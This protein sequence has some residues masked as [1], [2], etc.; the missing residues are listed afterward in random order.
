MDLG[1][2]EEDDRQD[3]PQRRAPMD[4]TTLKTPTRQEAMIPLTGRQ[5]LDSLDDGREVW[6]YG[7]RVKNVAE[8]PAFR[9]SARM[10]AR[11]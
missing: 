2:R 6:I 4:A 9:N 1:G 5:Y 7:K 8:H 11:L 3:S 10:I